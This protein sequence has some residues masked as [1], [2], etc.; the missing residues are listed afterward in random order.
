M[1]FSR[2]PVTLA[3]DAGDLATMQYL[4]TQG[5]T[6]ADLRADTTKTLSHAC[7]GGHLHIVQYLMA[8]GFSIDDLR[9]H[10]NHALHCACFEGHLNIVQYLI[11]QGLTAEDLRSGE[12][13][14]S[15]KDYAL[16]EAYQ[17]GH[18]AI[19][20]ALITHAHY[21]RTE[22]AAILADLFVEQLMCRIARY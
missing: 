2:W 6:L 8:Q 4:E 5:F 17:A 14:Q 12:D 7:G 18:Y 20:K 3:C 22:L 1:K 10:H 19:I 15:E 13:P 11:A 21:T 16:R 9:A